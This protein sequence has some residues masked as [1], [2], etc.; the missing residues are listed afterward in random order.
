MQSKMAELQLVSDWPIFIFH[1]FTCKEEKF[2]LFLKN[3][4]FWILFRDASTGAISFTLWLKMADLQLLS[5]WLIYIFYYF[6]CKD[7]QFQLIQI[8]L[9]KILLRHFYWFYGI[10]SA[11]KN[12]RLTSVLGLAN[13]HFPLFHLEGFPTF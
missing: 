13:K 10:H 2:Q 11:V 9:I 4:F 1:Y 8:Y 3:L 6:T 7:E 12:G 5:D